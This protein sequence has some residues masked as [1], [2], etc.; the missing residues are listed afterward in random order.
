MRDYDPTTGRYIE[1]DP[2]GLVDGASVYGYARQSPGRWVDPRGE[3]AYAVVSGIAG[4]DLLKPDKSDLKPVK[5]AAYGCAA[6]LALAIDAV[7]S[8]ACGCED[9]CPYEM[10]LSQLRKATKKQMRSIIGSIGHPHDLKDGGF[11]DMWVSP[12]GCVYIGNKDGTGVGR[13]VGKI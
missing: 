10:P 2:L 1:P 13:L 8:E 11:E 9:N 12:E 6:V 5:W 4:G 3:D 7:T